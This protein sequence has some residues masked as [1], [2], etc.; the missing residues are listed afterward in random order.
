MVMPTSLSQDMKVKC[1]RRVT[2]RTS[3][4]A[5]VRAEVLGS[6]AAVLAHV[7]LERIYRGVH[8]HRV[9]CKATVKLDCSSMPVDQL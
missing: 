1:Q 8:A 7:T 6:L 4:E 3:E 5:C 9:C 2:G